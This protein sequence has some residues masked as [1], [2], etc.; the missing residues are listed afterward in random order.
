MLTHKPAANRRGLSLHNVVKSFYLPMLFRPAGFAQGLRVL[1]GDQ[2]IFCRRKAFEAVGGYDA[3]LPIMEDADLC[4]RLHHP[5]QKRLHTAPGGR[6][7]H[8]RH[9]CS[10]SLRPPRHTR[11][12]LFIVLVQCP[13]KGKG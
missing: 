2:V 12:A 4:V 1:F 13:W 9:A 11:L 8:A 6:P 10:R 5:A 3:T 7:P